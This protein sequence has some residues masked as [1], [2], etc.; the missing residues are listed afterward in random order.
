MDPNAP[1]FD[2]ADARAQ[3]VSKEVAEKA[4]EEGG[5][6]KSRKSRTRRSKKSKKSRR[7]GGASCGM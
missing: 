1:E 5:R 3:L 2:P 6:R 4:L 7:R